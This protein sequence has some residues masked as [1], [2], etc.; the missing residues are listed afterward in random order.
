[1]TTCSKKSIALLI[2]LV[3]VLA[4]TA[5][6]P[7][8]EAVDD[9]DD[10]V[11]D[12]V[13]EVTYKTELVAAMGEEIQ[14]TDHQQVTTIFGLVNGLISTPPMS[15]GLGNNQILPH[16][17]QS[18]EVSEDG[19]E[20]RFTFDPS[21]TYH[22]GVPATAESYKQAVDRYLDI[23]PYAYD[24]DPV[25]EMIVDGDTLIMKLD[26][27]GP[28]M[29]VLTSSSYGAPVEVGAAD[30]MGEDA[31]GRAAV[32]CGP[33]IVDEWVDGSHITMV[34][35]DDHKNYLPFV[36]N[37]E[38]FHFEKVTVRFIPESLTRISELRAGSVDLILGVPGEQLATLEQDPDIE[39]HG[40]LGANVRYIEMNTQIFP[41][42]D[43][44]VR[45]AIA[46]A[47]DRDELAAGVND[48]IVPNFSMAG[49]AMI[50]HSPETEQRLSE[51]Y[52]TDVDRARELLLEAGWEPGS[53]GIM[54]KDGERL[55]IE[56]AI[57]ADRAVNTRAAPIMQAQLERAGID[58]ALREFTRPY[59]RE[60]VQAG[61]F[62][63]ALCDWSWLDPGGIWPYSHHSQGS[64]S[65]FGDPEIDALMDAACEEPDE[66]VGAQRWG[67]VS[68]AMWEK[69]PIFP[70]WSD[71]HFL[72]TRAELT[73][74]Q[75]GVSGALYL[76]DVKV[77]IR[78]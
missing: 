62:D 8:E 32:G 13:E 33:Y 19:L 68:E 57:N 63:M 48:V 12:P 64:M 45:L 61:D 26:R 77:E 60:I 40:Y 36:E 9:P 39:V 46:L 14:S 56:F 2:A 71:R 30:E 37:N 38:A 22:N 11:D 70:V 43:I 15:M 6:A 72:A 24:W 18:V 29:F 23:G 25:E 17:A 1:M 47:L 50:R 10:P 67:E 49:P 74:L 55:S 78:E 44:N 41:L 65:Q 27:A 16:G 59:I 28:G 53:D 20:I 76:H 35:N 58:V 34:R 4:M 54:V 75:V 3:L 69:L 7:P 66:T 42:D 51:T 21:R 31:F 5:C 52:G 73:G